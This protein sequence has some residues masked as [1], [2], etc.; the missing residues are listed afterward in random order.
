MKKLLLLLFIALLFACQEDESEINDPAQSVIEYI[1][2]RE[3]NIFDLH[4]YT[5]KNNESA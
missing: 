4:R 3:G 1:T 5:L 2:S